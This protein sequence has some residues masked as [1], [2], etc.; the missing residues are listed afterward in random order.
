RALVQHAE[1]YRAAWNEASFRDGLGKAA[2]GE[3]LGDDVWGF[4]I[5]LDRLDATR[6]LL[7]AMETR[8]ES[9]ARPVAERLAAFLPAGETVRVTVHALV[10]GSSDG[11][12]PGDGDFYLALHYFS[13]DEEGV[14]L[15]MSHE[16]FHVLRR[17]LAP[18]AKGGA[19]EPPAQEAA[20]RAL[21]E[22][23]MNE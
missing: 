6:R 20:A 18:P 10:G 23:T 11:F 15:L 14:R 7:E 2:R 3:P 21:L 8:P 9:F 22:Q 16:L 5:V 17:R 19:A 13:G 1:A 4:R 12:A